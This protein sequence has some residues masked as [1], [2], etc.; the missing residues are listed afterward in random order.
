M[1]RTIADVESKPLPGEAESLS[2]FS[3]QLRAFV[4]VLAERARVVSRAADDFPNREARD[5]WRRLLA[6][7]RDA[8]A[9]EVARD[10]PFIASARR[11]I[12]APSKGV[13]HRQRQVAVDVFLRKHP[14]ATLSE[15]YAAVGKKFNV[16]ADAIRKSYRRMTRTR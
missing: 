1:T 2:E 7:L 14:S 12:G 6:H 16:K 11:R 8:P 5:A 15:A 4:E 13:V 9:Y 3:D 10:L